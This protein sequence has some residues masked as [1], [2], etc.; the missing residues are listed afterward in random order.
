MPPSGIAPFQAIAPQN[1][2]LM[3]IEI[4]SDDY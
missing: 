4:K 3:I 2:E 1:P